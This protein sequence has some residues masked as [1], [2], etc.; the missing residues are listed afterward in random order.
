[1]WWDR[2]LQRRGATR[3]K[4]LKFTVVRRAGGTARVTEEEDLRAVM[5]RSE[6]G[7]GVTLWT[8]PPRIWLRHTVCVR[9]ELVDSGIRLN[10]P[11]AVLQ[12]LL[13]SRHELAESREVPRESDLSAGTQ[14]EALKGKR[15][16]VQ[17]STGSC[18]M[19]AQFQLP[20]SFCFSDSSWRGK[21]RAGRW[22]A[23]KSGQAGNWIID[24]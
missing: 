20:Y 19:Y 8:L 11:T 10:K 18:K 16:G 4:A 17:N 15:D 5:C 12:H 14:P 22:V 23:V 1:M 24:K 2:E 6:R 9:F 13:K 21:R 7:G 3:L